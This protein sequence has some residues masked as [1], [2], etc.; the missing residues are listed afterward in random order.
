MLDHDGKQVPGNYGYRFVCVC[1]PFEKLDSIY[2]VVVVVV[3]VK[4]KK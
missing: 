4:K 3:V 1:F 2:W